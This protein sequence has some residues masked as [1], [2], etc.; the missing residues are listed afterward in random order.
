M[1]TGGSTSCT[2]SNTINLS[3]PIIIG[4]FIQRNLLLFL[5]F[6]PRCNDSKRKSKYLKIENPYNYFNDVRTVHTVG[7]LQSYKYYG[8]PQV[9][10]ASANAGLDYGFGFLWDNMQQ[11]SQGKNRVQTSSTMWK[12]TEVKPKSCLMFILGMRAHQQN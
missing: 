9:K 10:W 5:I 3:N 12:F 11:I 4:G 8:K 6:F 7:F 2:L 1:L